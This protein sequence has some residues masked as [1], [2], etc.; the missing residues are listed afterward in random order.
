MRTYNKMM[1]ALV[2]MAVVNAA[3]IGDINLHNNENELH[4]VKREPAKGKFRGQT[5]SQY[6][7]FGT[8]EDGKAEAEATVTSSRATVAGRNGMGQAQSQS[9]GADCSD[10]Y[11]SGGVSG[12]GDHYADIQRPDPL[13]SVSDGR[14]I[15]DSS[16]YPNGHQSHDISGGGRYIPGGALVT[17]DTRRPGT[18]VDAQGR[19][20]D[21]RFEDHS[22]G[23]PPTGYVPGYPGGR[24]GDVIGPDGRVIQGG[25]VPGAVDSSGRPIH[26]GTTQ[27]PGQTLRPIGGESIGAD[28]TPSL[29]LDSQGR[30][31]QATTPQYVDAHGRP[32]DSQGRPIQGGVTQV[33]TQTTT[34]QFVDSQGR[35]V[36]NQGRLLDAQGRPI[37]QQQTT[38]H[39]VDSQGRVVDSQGRPIQ[40]GSTQVPTQTTTSQFVDAHGRP[41]DSQGR[42]IDAQGRPIQGGTTQVDSDGRP[43]DSQGRPIQGGITQVP[44]QTTTSQ[45]VDSQGRPVDSQGRLLDAQGRPVQG[46]VTQ[47]PSQTTT[48]QFVDSQ[49][50]PV[51]SQGRLLDAQ[52]RPVQGGGTQVPTQQYV[53][54]HGRPVD[55]QG[56]LI[57]AYGRPIDSFRPGTQFEHGR[58]DIPGHLGGALTTDSQRTPGSTI[59]SETGYHHTKYREKTHYITVPGTNHTVVNP[60]DGLT[61]LIGTGNPRQTVIGSD[62]RL[63]GSGPVK[64]Y[65]GSDD[66]RSSPQ[67]TVYGKEG[68]LTV[69]IGT[70]GPTQTVHHVSAVGPDGKPCITTDQRIPG[71]GEYTLGPSQQPTHGT[72]TGYISP[73]QYLP[74]TQTT[75]QV[76]S[77]GYL[78]PGQQLPGTQTGQMPSAG[79]LTPGQQLPGIQTTGQMP[80]TGY[81]T[82]GQQLPG[83]QTGQTP[84]TGYLTPGQQ[85]PGTHTGQMPSTGYLT[86][87]QQLPGTQTTGQMPSTGY[88]TPGQQLPGT[89][90][91]QIPST[92]YLTPGQQLPGT[93]TGQMPST[94]YLTPGQQLPGTQTGQMPSTGYLTPGQQLPGTQTGQMPSTGYLTP[95]QQLPGTQTGQIPSTGYLTPGQQ[96]PGTQ[97]QVVGPYQHQ[98][99]QIPTG[100]TTG[101]YVPGGTQGTGGYSTPGQQYPTGPQVLGP[102]YQPG[103]SGGYLAPGQQQLAPGIHPQ[104]VGQYKQPGSQV[105]TG[106]YVPGTQG[107][108]GTQTGALPGTLPTQGQQFGT[109]YPSTSGKVYIPGVGYVDQQPSGQYPTQ[110]GYQ[111]TTQGQQQ[112]TGGQHTLPGTGG[113][114][115][116]HG[117]TTGQLPGTTTSQG[118][119]YPGTSGPKVYV[120]GVGYVDAGQ[121]LSYPV[122]PGTHQQG[123]TGYQPSVTGGQQYGAGQLGVPGTGG[124]STGQQT[125]SGYL[126]PG[127]QLPGTHTTGYVNGY[128]TQTGGLP[129]GSTT[130]QQI[131][132]G[133]PST[134]GKVYIPGVGYVDAQQQ[135]TYTQYPGAQQPG[136]TYVP[137]IPS[138]SQVLAPGQV[139]PTY[140]PGHGQVIP[141]TSGGSIIAEP[142]AKVTG[143]GTSSKELESGEV[144]EEDDDS[145]SQAETSIKEGEVVASAQGR[146]NGGT[147]KT[148]VSG[149]YKEGGSFSASAQTSDSDRGAQAQVQGGKDGAMTSAQGNG[150]AAQSQSQ[151]SVNAKNGATSATAQSSGV[152]HESQSEVEASEKGGLADAQAEGPGRTSSQAQIGFKPID[153]N[154]VQENHIFNGGGQSSASSSKYS[155]QSQSQINGKFKYGISYHGAS[156]SASGSKDH[157][158]KYREQNKLVFQ[159]ISSLQQATKKTEEDS[160]TSSSTQRRSQQT[161]SFDVSTTKKPDQ[162]TADPEE[163]DDDDDEE[164]D[165]EEQEYPEMER[166]GGPVIETK[167]STTI[168]DKDDMDETE[169]PLSTTTTLRP[170]VN[171]KAH[172][173]PPK[174]KLFTQTS[175]GQKQ[176][177]VVANSNEPFKIVQT[178]NGR[179]VYHPRTATQKS[180]PTTTEKVPDGFK[181][182]EK[183][184]VPQSLSHKQERKEVVTTKFLPSKAS[185]QDIEKGK[186]PDSFVTVTKQIT[187]VNEDN[188]PKLP[189]I[190]GKNFESTYY[191]KSSTCGYFTFTC[192]IVYGANG[193]SKICRPK[194][195]TNGKC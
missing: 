153:E 191:T 93:Q 96:L 184:G 37:D 173:L 33:P 132:T 114:V 148:Q 23:R 116:G 1:I 89:Q 101:H 108:Y 42:V 58:G 176:A 70:G 31:I 34:S 164:E 158:A 133:Y 81:L 177:A 10:C 192:N 46:G 150:G 160:Q 16:R 67:Q 72:S 61:V 151:L 187:G 17:G 190:P 56:R 98:G 119:G 149:S 11:G 2:M 21:T 140:I 188:K 41:V 99:G 170:R 104:G 175:P 30:P 85:L 120:P 156:Q 27:I 79:Y 14:T 195:P 19:P 146:K 167:S 129:A 137:G 94:G 126:T 7:N 28:G 118:T 22:N 131:G 193:R 130:G 75:A 154:E 9:S 189:G 107:G 165:Y 124:V 64:I 52:G 102:S 141:Q 125:S 110:P 77:T 32:V 60:T 44:P 47:V 134:A 5:Q 194:P 3:Y 113:Y 112:Y 178:Q 155:G 136:G 20:I 159:K 43:I 25:V 63:D 12:G 111:P 51:D 62:S 171:F 122:G 90:T 180:T 166:E 161:T 53:D 55:S 95:G 24:P 172:T 84:S 163:Y 68:G 174:P 65:P 57:D 39:Y 127:Q 185:A 152:K 145:Y 45:F 105:H 135:P 121:Q 144:P 73:G 71:G 186:M 80:S 103:S 162:Y 4:R 38:P 40:G 83:T 36:D 128:G 138:Y 76:P 78:T 92:G 50:R 87:G 183:K 115:N 59:V 142:G 147:A 106:Q 49:G 168:D 54:S 29:T 157:V 123:G 143:T 8:E 91:G 86:P 69:L 66:G 74:G 182:I 48:S 97:H 117:Q 109:G 18:V 139:Q 179:S 6:M 35:P 82:P 88:L 15:Q 13:T 26:G 169:L 100:G 181:E